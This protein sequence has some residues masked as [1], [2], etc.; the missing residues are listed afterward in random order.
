MSNTFTNRVI[1]VSGEKI[2]SMIATDSAFR[3]LSKDCKTLEEFQETFGKTI[4]LVT[5]KEIKYESIKSIKKEAGDDD[6]NISSGMLGGAVIK[7]EN[8]SDCES[9]L[10]YCEKQIGLKRNEVQMSVLKAIQNYLIGLVLAIAGTVFAYGRV[11]DLAAGIVNDPEGYS[12]SDRKTRS[13]NNIL[14]MLGPNG[15]LLIGLAISAFIAY[16]IWKRYQTPPM[17][18][19]LKKD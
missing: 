9:F 5:K 8:P 2:E 12:R 14:E 3:F 4:T 19:E 16:I 10:D 15:V 6:V 7:F 18:T 11:N 17:L 1:K 13:M